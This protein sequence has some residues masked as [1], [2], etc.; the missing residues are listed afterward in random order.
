MLAKYSVKKPLTVILAGMDDA[1]GDIG[2][3]MDDL[4]DSAIGEADSGIAE[5]QAQQAEFSAKLDELLAGER[6]LE[7]GKIAL[8]TGLADAKRQIEEKAAALEQARAEFGSSRD[9]ALEQA[10]V[11]GLVTMQTVHTL[12]EANNFSIPAVSLSQN[13]QAVPVKVGAFYDIF[14]RKELKEGELDDA[15]SSA[16]SSDADAQPSR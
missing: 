8:S 13:G 9:A 2:Q 3:T 11:G 1:T 12:L 4:L 6:Q 5:A 7:Q 10:G 16:D 15:L 14:R